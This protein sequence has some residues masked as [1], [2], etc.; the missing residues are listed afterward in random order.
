MK[1]RKLKLRNDNELMITTEE[2]C[3]CVGVCVHGCPLTSQ[4]G[5]YYS[6]QF[7]VRCQFGV[8]CKSDMRMRSVFFLFLPRH[9]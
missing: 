7:Y 3:F 9:R 6:N 8:T 1:M 2:A 4:C 5:K